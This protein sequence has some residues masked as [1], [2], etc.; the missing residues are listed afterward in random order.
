MLVLRS[1]DSDVGCEDAG[2]IKLSLCL[3]DVGLRSN[4]T[5]ETVLS[6]FLGFLI[7]THGI[8]E[9]LFLCIC[10]ANLKAIDGNF[11]VNT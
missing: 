7:G 5:L 9:K 3:Y 8:V 4:P 1:L 2:G 10:T 6:Q 11:C